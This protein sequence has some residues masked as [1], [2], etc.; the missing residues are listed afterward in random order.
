[1]AVAARGG[2]DSPDGGAPAALELTENPD[3]LKT[4]ATATGNRRPALVVGFAAETDDIVKNATEKRAR[5]GCDW[6]LAND[7]SPASG[8]FGGDSN[9]LHLV[10]D[11]GVEDW[12]RMSKAAAADRLAGC[13]A[14]YFKGHPLR[15]AEAAS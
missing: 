12:P 6:L 5:K 1:M 7:V 15:E 4:I 11:G 8:T 9:T 14:D 10:R 2:R 13:V 3:I